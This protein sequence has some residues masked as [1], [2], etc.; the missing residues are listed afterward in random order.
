MLQFTQ[1]L[2]D[3]VNATT[4]QHAPLYI[5]RVVIEQKQT[6]MNYQKETSVPFLKIITVRPN[7]ATL[8]VE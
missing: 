4:R 8:T 5:R 1:A 6:I 2:N 7:T 3:A